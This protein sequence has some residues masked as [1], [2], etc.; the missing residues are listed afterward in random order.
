MAGG[1]AQ[2]FL[3]KDLHCKF[4]KVMK[5]QLSICHVIAHKTSKV[6][7]TGCGQKTRAC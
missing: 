2:L 6:R 3:E 5:V 7:K 1:S 4:P